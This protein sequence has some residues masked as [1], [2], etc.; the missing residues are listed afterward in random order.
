M[1]STDTLSVFSVNFNKGCFK[2]TAKVDLYQ[3]TLLIYG[4]LLWLLLDCGSNAKRLLTFKLY[5]RIRYPLVI[6]STCNKTGVYVYLGIYWFHLYRPLPTNLVNALKPT[7]GCRSCIRFTV[8]VRSASPSK[9]GSLNC[10]TTRL[11]CISP[12]SHI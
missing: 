5:L 3:G 7:A 6:R 1:Y 10:T 2:S 9:G 8:S 12:Q 11:L 4:P